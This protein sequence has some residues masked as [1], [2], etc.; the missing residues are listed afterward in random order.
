MSDDSTMHRRAQIAEGKLAKLAEMYRDLE[1]LVR[2]MGDGICPR[3]Y[4]Y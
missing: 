2:V 1:G 3:S 4:V